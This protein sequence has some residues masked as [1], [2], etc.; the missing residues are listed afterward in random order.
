MGL[1][2]AYM[3][4]AY[5]GNVQSILMVVL[6]PKGRLFVSGLRCKSL[7]NPYTVKPVQSSPL[8]KSHIDNVLLICASCIK[9]QWMFFSIFRNSENNSLLYISWN[10]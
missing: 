8:Y 1:D 3:C 7:V 2:G 10:L 9:L 4:T 5:V 6:A